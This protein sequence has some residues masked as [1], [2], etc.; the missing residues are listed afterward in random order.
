MII[1]DKIINKWQVLRTPGDSAKMAEIMGNDGYPEIFNRAFREGRCNDDVFKI[2][3]DF[4][5][6]KAN[7][8]KQYL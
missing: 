2:M 4:Y 5:E 1:P 6:E 8:I 7:L 3:A